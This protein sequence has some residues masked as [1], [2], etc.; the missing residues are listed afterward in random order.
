MQTGRDIGIRITRT[1]P[2]I[3]QIIHP[4]EMFFE[5][6]GD[7]SYGSQVC[8]NKNTI[9][10]SAGLQVHFNKRFQLSVESVE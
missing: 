9:Q 2:F 1:N 3:H 6:R 4:T 8:K 5:R 7:D 10:R